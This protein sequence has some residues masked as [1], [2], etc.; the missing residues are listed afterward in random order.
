MLSYLIRRILL[1]VPTL[2]GATF[3]IFSLMA[4]APISIT[5]VLLPPTG[6]MLPG[7]RAEREAYIEERYGLDQPF[8]IQYLRWLNN[9]SPIGFQTYKRDDPEVVPVLK[10]RREWREQ[11]EARLQAAN[12]D[13][14]RDDLIERRKALEE[15]QDFAP[16]P[17]QIRWDRVPLKVPTLGYSYV[18]ARPV[19]GI[20]AEALPVTLLLNGISLPIA[21]FVA[22][23]TGVW[24]ARFRG[25]WQDWGIGTFLLMLSA[26]P[27]IWTGVMLIGYFANDHYLNWFPAAGLH[28]MTAES[29]RFFPSYDADGDWHRGYLLDTL[30]HL[31][32]PVICLS[33]GAFAY[34]SKL[35]RTSLLETIGADFVRTAHAKGVAPRVVLWR[36]AFRNSLLPLITVTAALLPVLVT[37][38]I[39]V[40]TIFSINGMGRLAF[41]SLLQNDRELFLSVSLITLILQLG[42]FLLADIAY[43]LADPRVSFDK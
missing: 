25:G 43:A 17:G 31:A 13:L 22:V 32:L 10:A 19:E 7:A 28:D 26:V 40:E 21:L 4:A 24:A 27:V 14:E 39:V 8:V 33:Y 6:Q 41:T 5:D 18:Q 15:K 9:I 23:M 42:G 20:L 38:S 2:I 34:Y 35:T 3:V 12:P 30:W 1:F 37:G 29:A 36:H 16:L 11:A